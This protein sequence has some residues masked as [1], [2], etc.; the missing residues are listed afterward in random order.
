MDD[1]RTGRRWTIGELAAATGVSVRSLRHYDR[2]GLLEPSGRTPAGHRRY[3]DA[4]VRRLH[5]LVVLRGFGLSL[6]GVGHVLDGGVDP[7]L[8]LRRQAERV[9]EQLAATLRLQRTLSDVLARL[10]D[11]DGPASDDLI[12]LL[13][14]MT[15]MHRPLTPE[16]LDAMTRRRRQHAEALTPQQLRTMAEQR[17]AA[18]EAMTEDQRVELVAARA[19]VTPPGWSAE[20]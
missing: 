13:E 18:W 11:V 10:D 2:I 9:A 14:E 1:E 8:L 3:T 6:E 15:T 12:T 17:S 4:E 5:H 7:V 19:A 20:S 16:E